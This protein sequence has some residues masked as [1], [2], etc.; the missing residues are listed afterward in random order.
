MGNVPYEK[1]M[2]QFDWADLYVFTS[3]RDAGATVVVEALGH[4]VPVICLDHSGA[5][6]VVTDQCG[7]KIPVRTPRDAV[8]DLLD[9]I[10][11]IAAEPNRLHALSHGAVERARMYLW[12]RNGLHMARLY[13]EALTSR[14]QTGLVELS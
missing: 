11:R 10:V 1:A 7:V 3:L 5:R 9:A 6:D 12:E 13:D 14:I 2:Q 4:G 8:S